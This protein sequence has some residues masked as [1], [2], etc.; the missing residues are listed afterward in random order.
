MRRRDHFF[1]SDLAPGDG[2]RPFG[3]LGQIAPCIRPEQL[4]RQ[5]SGV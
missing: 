5:A 1:R 2:T 3:A 4:V